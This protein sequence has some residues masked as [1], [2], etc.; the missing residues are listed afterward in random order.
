MQK[1][2]HTAS[3]FFLS[4]SLEMHNC[5]NALGWE[6]GHRPQSG[7]DKWQYLYIQLSSIQI[8]S[9]QEAGNRAR[10]RH[11]CDVGPIFLCRLAQ[12]IL[13]TKH[14][15]CFPLPSNATLIV[16]Q[17]WQSRKS[18]QNHRCLFDDH[19]GSPCL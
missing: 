1:K 8:C 16:L 3:T 18:K 4:L 12:V 17:R 10:A 5:T 9:S 7:T 11:H 2:I 6:C 14:I 15:I 19:A 13:F